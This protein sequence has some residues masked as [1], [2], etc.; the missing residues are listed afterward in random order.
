MTKMEWNTE[1]TVATIEPTPNETT[2][3]TFD[4][5]ILDEIIDTIESEYTYV[6]YLQACRERKERIAQAREV[7]HTTCATAKAVYDAAKAEPV[8]LPP[9]CA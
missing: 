9:N 1:P 4:P 6:Q 8:P 2:D 7:Y 3:P 5:A